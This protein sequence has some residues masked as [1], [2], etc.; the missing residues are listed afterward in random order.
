[1]PKR[2]QN[3]KQ[4]EIALGS[5]R[6]LRRHEEVGLHLQT[7]RGIGF[8]GMEWRRQVLPGKRESLGV[9]IWDEQVV[10][11]VQRGSGMLA[12]TGS[13]VMKGNVGKVRS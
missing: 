9:R 2:T 12:A 4:G 13:W 1:M 3:S 8:R 6:W 7:D 10:R 5:N 11:S